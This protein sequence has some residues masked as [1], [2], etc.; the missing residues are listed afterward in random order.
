MK[1]FLIPILALVTT[2]PVLALPEPVAGPAAEL[3][4]P[5]VY[6]GPPVKIRKLET[7][8]NAGVVKI[9]VLHY[10]KCPRTS[11]KSMGQY[12]KG[13]HITLKCYTRDH[14]SV[15]SGDA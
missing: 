15:V 6:S 10:H 5:T 3:P 2:L 13:T 1:L 12:A 4:A 11:C 9:S 8:D 7:R 14:T